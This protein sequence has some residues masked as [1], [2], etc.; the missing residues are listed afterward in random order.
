LATM[1]A[2]A[3]ALGM[4]TQQQVDKPAEY[5]ASGDAAIVLVRAKV[6]AGARPGDTFDVD[7]ECLSE[8]KDTKSLRG[9]ILLACT[10]RDVADVS[11]LSKFSQD[12][13]PKLKS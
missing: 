5:L 11:Q 1:V 12:K 3:A 9:V 6:P 2:G 4:L 10:L 13:A 7:V 8:D